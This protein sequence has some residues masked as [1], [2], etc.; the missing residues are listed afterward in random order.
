MDENT[1]I[2]TTVNTSNGANDESITNIEDCGGKNNY[3]SRIIF[4]SLLIGLYSKKIQFLLE[5]NLQTEKTKSLI[6]KGQ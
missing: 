5:R 6:I 1:S 4:P 2:N 3:H